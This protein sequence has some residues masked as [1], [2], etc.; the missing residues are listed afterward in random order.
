MPSISDDRPSS[1]DTTEI[2]IGGDVPWV[3]PLV[4]QVGEILA[5][6]LELVRDHPEHDVASLL[7]ALGTLSD[8]L[9]AQAG[10]NEEVPQAFWPASAAIMQALAGYARAAADD[11]A[12]DRGE[13]SGGNPLG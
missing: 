1:G 4:S 10:P 8:Q 2:S 9:G 6:A 13:G 3:L 5:G 11:R 7:A 12:R